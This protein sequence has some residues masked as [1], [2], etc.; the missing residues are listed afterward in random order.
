MDPLRVQLAQALD[1][2]G[3]AREDAAERMG[4]TVDQLSG[5]LAGGIPMSM[6]WAERAAALVGKRVRV[7]LVDLR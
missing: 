2:R 5:M 7:D 6:Y 3:I 4:C 1:A